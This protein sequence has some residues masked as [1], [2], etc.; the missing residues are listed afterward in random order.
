[1]GFGAGSEPSDFCWTYVT[2]IFEKLNDSPPDTSSR[3][4]GV[5][6]MGFTLSM[7]PD[8][9]LLPGYRDGFGVLDTIQAQHHDR[10]L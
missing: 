5:N 7:L 9:A 3:S 10:D 2:S 8:I 1:L 6:S 4:L